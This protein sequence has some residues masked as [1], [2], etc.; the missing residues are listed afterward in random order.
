MFGN[1]ELISFQQKVP[2]YPGANLYWNARIPSLVENPGV[3]VEMRTTT[4]S[5]WVPSGNQKVTVQIRSHESSSFIFS[6][7]GRRVQ[8][9]LTPVSVINVHDYVQKVVK[10]RKEGVLDPYL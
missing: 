4:D 2:S 8:M 1:G 5:V 7:N 6:F 10:L 3:T 9:E